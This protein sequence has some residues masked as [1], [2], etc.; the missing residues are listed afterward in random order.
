MYQ[1]VSKDDLG[2]RVVFPLVK[3]KT[4]IGRDHGCDIVLDDPEV[5][6]QHLKI[7]FV[8]G[9][10]Q[11]KD[12]ESR[13][14][15]FL[16]SGK[17]ER[18]SRMDLSDQLIVGP[19]LFFLEQ[20]EQATE[21]EVGLTCMLTV[22]QL[23]ELGDNPIPESD[24][25]AGEMLEATSIIDHRE[26]MA[27]IYKKQIGLA[28]HPSLEVLF[29]PDIGRRFLLPPGNY[30][31]GRGEGCNIR[32]SDDKASSRHGTVDSSQNGIVYKDSESLNGTLLNNKIVKKA[33][34][35]HRDILMIGKTKLRVLDPKTAAQMRQDDKHL[36]VS[37]GQS[38][39]IRFDSMLAIAL[40]YWYLTLPVAIALLAA[41]ILLAIR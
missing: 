11:L 13:N 39:G 40:D 28:K 23:R 4:I 22:A 31:L 14:G 3:V 29:G 17:I 41:V 35:K 36:P 12:N 25:E 8:D 18:M 6:R 19:N 1:L 5:S 27:G 21:E 20:V 32:L 7:Y 34:L 2:R 24:A 33:K 30:V 10:V 37:N 16:N 9:Q 26:L 38:L 15:T